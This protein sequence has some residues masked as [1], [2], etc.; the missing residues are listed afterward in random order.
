[1][2]KIAIGLFVLFCLAAT[3]SI[4]WADRDTPERAAKRIVQECVEDY[5]TINERQICVTEK[6]LKWAGKHGLL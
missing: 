4:V 6:F 3:A 2:I 5:F 1:V